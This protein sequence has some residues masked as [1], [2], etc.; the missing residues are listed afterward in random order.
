LLSLSLTTLHQ[1]WSVKFSAPISMYSRLEVWGAVTGSS[2][3]CDDVE[4]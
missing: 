3:V 2:R 4:S 1:P